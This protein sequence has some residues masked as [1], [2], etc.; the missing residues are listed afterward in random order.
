[1]MVTDPLCEKKRH[2]ALYAQL[3]A[4]ASS[5]RAESKYEEESAGRW[6]R[7]RD[8][9]HLDSSEE[10]LELCG[11]EVVG[12]HVVGTTL[13]GEREEAAAR[14]SHASAQTER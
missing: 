5:L 12:E 6:N 13:G 8:E 2:Y 1:M 10:G 3:S 4:S 7:E 11:P 14:H 9:E